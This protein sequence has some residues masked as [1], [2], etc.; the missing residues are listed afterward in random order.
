MSFHGLIAHFFIS[1][2]NSPLFEYT[3]VYLSI[4]LWKDILIAAM[5]LQL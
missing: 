2:N 5:F 4:H 1:L 3:V